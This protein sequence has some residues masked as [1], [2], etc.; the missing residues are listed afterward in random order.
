MAASI[1]RLLY[2]GFYMAASMSK[3][4]RIDR[5]KCDH[6]QIAVCLIWSSVSFILL[7]SSYGRL[8]LLYTKN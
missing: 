3:K 7:S 4:Q 2:G 6:V 8:S 5:E 1:W